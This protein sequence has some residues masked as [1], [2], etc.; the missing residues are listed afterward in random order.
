MHSWSEEQ[1]LRDLGSSIA[2][3]VVRL[4][5]D[6]ESYFKRLIGAWPWIDVSLD[7]S[8]I[9]GCRY[10]Y[11]AS[12]RGRRNFTLVE[13]ATEL[14]SFWG[15][16][17]RELRITADA[18]ICVLGD[19][20]LDFVLRMPAQIFTDHLVDIFSIPMHWYVF[21]DDVDWCFNYRIHGDAYFGHRP[22]SPS[23]G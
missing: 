4:D 13:P 1:I 20:D 22:A 11:P 12:R 10:L 3:G 21:P 15:H 2:T 16:A 9:A 19:T 17:R 6:L 23:A 14:R 5:E 18:E 7:W 8:D